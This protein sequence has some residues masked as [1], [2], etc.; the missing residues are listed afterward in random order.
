[1]VWGKK[2]FLCCGAQCYIAPTRRQQFEE[3]VCWMWGVQSDFASTF[4][5]SGWVQLLEVREGCTSNSLSSP[6]YLL[7][8]SEVRLGSW[9][10]SDSYWS[11]ED[12]LNYGRLEL[13]Q[14]L[15]WQVELSQL[16]KE[17]QPQLGLFD[18]RVNV[19]VPLQVLRDGG[20]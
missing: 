11:A 6:D 9:A 4:A 14:Q 10:E 3:E 1:M 19:I 7:Q 5:H 12:V 16:V 13:F 8:S 17:V 20:A 18:N 2:I 15:L